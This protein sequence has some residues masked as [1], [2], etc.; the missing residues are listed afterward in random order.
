MIEIIIRNF[1]F[2]IFPAKPHNSKPFFFLK[3]NRNDEKESDEESLT[4]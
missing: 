1:F 3:G 2:L 4:S